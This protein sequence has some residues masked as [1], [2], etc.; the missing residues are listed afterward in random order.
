MGFLR[1]RLLR[2]FGILGRFADLALLL[3]A[4][5]RFA[6]RKGW[7]SEQQI[8]SLGLERFAPPASRVPGVSAGAMPLGEMAVAGSAAFRLL[9]RKKSTSR[10]RLRRR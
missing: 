6:S 5:L 2:R 7:I 9:R 8:S 3:G 10:R 4:A 1:N